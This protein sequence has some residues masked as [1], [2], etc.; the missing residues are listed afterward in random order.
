MQIMYIAV[1]T[2]MLLLLSKNGRL[3]YIVICDAY[4]SLRIMV[5]VKWWHGSGDYKLC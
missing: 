5:E 2:V 1:V 3:R 4:R